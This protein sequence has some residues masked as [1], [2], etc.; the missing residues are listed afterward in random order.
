M[1]IRNYGLCRGTRT[2]ASTA[3]LALGMTGFVVT[4]AKADEDV[5]SS[6][7]DT[8]SYSRPLVPEDLTFGSTAGTAG[9]AA[10]VSFSVVTTPIRI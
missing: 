7:P 4:S 6:P 10:G 5:R 1:R 8:T 2:L 9:L 3:L